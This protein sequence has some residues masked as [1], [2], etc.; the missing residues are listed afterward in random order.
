MHAEIYE[1]AGIEIKSIEYSYNFTEMYTSDAYT[2]AS[3]VESIPGVKVF[4]FVYLFF[5]CFLNMRAR[6]QLTPCRTLVHFNRQHYTY[7]LAT[8]FL[9]RL[10]ALLCAHQTAIYHNLLTNS[11]NE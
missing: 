7:L 2:D 4:F 8:R 6:L 3:A 5:V 11:M 10:C 9:F 1:N